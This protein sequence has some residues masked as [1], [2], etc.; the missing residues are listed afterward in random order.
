MGRAGGGVTVGTP[1]TLGR[2]SLQDRWCQDF[3]LCTDT[4]WQPSEI[5]GHQIFC[6]NSGNM[7]AKIMLM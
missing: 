5:L 2:A 1:G 7:D 4:F 3:V 6:G